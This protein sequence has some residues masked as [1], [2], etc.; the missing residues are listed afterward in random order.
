MRKGIYRVIGL[1]ILL[2]IGILSGCGKKQSVTEDGTTEVIEDTE[3]DLL[4]LIE[5]EIEEKTPK[6][7]AIYAETAEYPALAQFL[8][9]YYQMP[10][11]YQP[12]SRYYYN[13]VDLNEDGVQE[14][15]AIVVGDYTTE[16]AG[17]TALLL[18][19]TE[20]SFE[21]LETFPMIRTPV[22]IS[23]NMTNGW[24]DLIFSVYGGGVDPGYLIYRYSEG[25]YVNEENEFLESLDDSIS[26]QQI[27]SNN[28]I[29]DLDKGT[30]LTLAPEPA[31]EE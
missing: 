19:P 31:T 27:L 1:Q 25:I 21:V 13:Y 30:Y 12:E 17:D 9:D 22:L 7:T 28:L 29:D 15:L 16:S 5:M 2:C 10:E 23:D 4:D 20:V 11:E 14:I 18:V 3:E 6:L 24:H 26:G 8:I